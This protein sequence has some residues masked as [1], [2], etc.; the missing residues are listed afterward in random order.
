MFSTLILLF[1]AVTQ[2][3]ILWSTFCLLACLGASLC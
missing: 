3:L 1:Y 2:G